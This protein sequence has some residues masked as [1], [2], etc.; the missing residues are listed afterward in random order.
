[1]M[2]KVEFIESFKRR[3]K[4]FALRSIKLFQALPKTDEAGIIG[5]QYIRAATSVAA[6]Y[7]AACRA[8]SKA[9]FHSKMSI[10][11]EEADE[12]IFWLEILA[13]AG[14]VSQKNIE[15]L[16]KEINEILAVMSKARN[17]SMSQQKSY[18]LSRN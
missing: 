10:V 13:E 8:R 5:K 15:A 11:V 16:L 4:E 7:R 9:E 18:S 1:M 3:T 14:I 6:N 2:D 12:S 17:T